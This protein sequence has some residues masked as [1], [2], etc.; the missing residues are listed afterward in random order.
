MSEDDGMDAGEE[1]DLSQYFT[2]PQILVLQSIGQE[3]E[4]VRESVEKLGQLIAAL[5]GSDGNEH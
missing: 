1:F 3:I 2:E 5:F 4:E